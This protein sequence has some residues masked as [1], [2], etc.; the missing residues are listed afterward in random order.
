MGREKR[1]EFIPISAFQAEITTN[2]V[3]NGAIIDTAN[4]LSN[5]FNINALWTDGTFT[6]EFF[7]SDDSGMSGETA[8]SDDNLEG[9]EAGLTISGAIAQGDDLAS[10]AVVGT[11]RLVRLKV[12]S[13]GTTLGAFIVVNADQEPTGT[14]PS[15]RLSA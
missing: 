13:S 9:T 14:T 8:I 1:S 6:F 5:K 15:G 12:T 3:T 4:T 10:I 2:T 7:E 11:K